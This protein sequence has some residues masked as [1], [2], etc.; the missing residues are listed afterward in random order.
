MTHKATHLATPFTRTGCQE[1]PQTACQPGQQADNL[2]CSNV[3]RAAFDA[4]IPVLASYQL[5]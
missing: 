5:G 2:T 3:A 1:L 4:G